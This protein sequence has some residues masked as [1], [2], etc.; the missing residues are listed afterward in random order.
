MIRPIGPRSLGVD[1]VNESFTSDHPHRHGKPPAAV[2]RH[3]CQPRELARCAPP[4]HV[5]RGRAM[6]FDRASVRSWSSTMPRADRSPRRSWPPARVCGC[7]PGRIMRGSPPALM[8]AGESRLSPWLLV[9]NPDVEVAGG[10]L[11]QV[12]ARLDPHEADPD[13][14]PGIVGFGLRNPDGSP[15]GS[16]GVYP[17]LARTIWEQFIPRSRRKYQAGW[18]IRSGQVDWVTGA[19]M[20]V[21]SAMI[22]GLGGMDED[23]FL[24]YEEVAFSQAARRLGWRV[25]YDASVSVVHRHPL[26]NRAIS[27][28]MRVITRHSK[29][30]YFLKHLPRWQFLSLST[31]VATEAAVRGIWSRLLGRSEE[32][33]AWRTIG[34]IARRLRNEAEPR[35]R[36]VLTLAESVACSHEEHEQPPVVPRQGVFEAAE[37]RGENVE[38]PVTRAHRPHQRKNGNPLER[39]KDGATL[40]PLNAAGR[41]WPP[42]PS[43]TSGLPCPVQRKG[44]RRMTTIPHGR[45]LGL[46]IVAASAL[47][48]WLTAHTDVFFADGLRYI[49]Q[50]RA[51]DQGS[52]RQGFVRSVD[53]PIYPMAIAAVHRLIGGHDPRDWQMAAQVAAAISGV[54][55]VIPVYLISLEVFGPASAWLACFLLYLL[56]FN[57][58]VLADAL[59]E[60]TFLLFWSLGLWAALRFLRDGRLLWLPLVIALSVLAYLTRPEGLILPVALLGSL[61]LLSVFYAGEM[62][63][64]NRWCA[65][66]VLVAGPILAAGPFMMM[67]GGISTKP[68]I[69][70]VLGPGSRRPGDGRRTRKAA[71]SR[72]DDHQNHQHRRPGRGTGRRRGNQPTALAAGAPRHRGN[73]VVTHAAQTLAISRHD[74]RALQPG[75][76][77]AACDVRVLH[78]TPCHGR[79]LAVDSGQRGRA[80]SAGQHNRPGDGQADQSP[81]TRARARDHP[82]VRL[83]GLL[84]CSLGTAGRLGDRPRIP[85]LPAGR[86]VA[87][88]ERPSRRRRARPQGILALLRRASRDIRSQRWKRES[89]TPTCAGLSLTKPWYTVPGITARRSDQSS[90]TAGRSGSSPTSRPTAF[91]RSMCLTSPSPVTR[92]PGPSLNRRPCAVE[93]SARRNASTALPPAPSR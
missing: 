38:A 11:G 14:P 53:H 12:L 7:W 19:C 5:A 39:R 80:Q 84:P 49:A 41:T 44:M 85:R 57:G 37:L 27:P 70:R 48:W 67:K 66:G 2:D 63:R 83:A 13:G 55:L 54:L 64:K 90:A 82:Q 79:G 21:N 17:S 10:F 58:H 61:L 65:I 15:Q 45:R 92:W 89:T 4:D 50:A 8:P 22:A 24:Y 36:D 72:S 6:T 60:S 28:K 40:A 31:I 56:P 33:R 74:R 34:E 93:R 91:P 68:S 76:D 71:R 32:V 88:L 73:L 47:L 25:E 3:H 59:S 52:W 29:L 9:L 86:R 46:L 69:L 75:H 35:G 81:G 30:L 1:R 77:P 87:G 23:F 51:I 18:R 20:L 16:V 42:S 43:Q 26:Q 62:P 78:A